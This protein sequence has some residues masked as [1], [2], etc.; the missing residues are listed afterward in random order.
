MDIF[1]SDEHHAL[2]IEVV[3]QENYKT[4]FDGQDDTTQNFLTYQKMEGRAGQIAVLYDS[5]GQ[6]DYVVVIADQE[7][8]LGSFGGLPKI[9]PPHHYKIEGIACEA[10][11]YQAHK[12]I[13]MGA[14][15]FDQ[16]KSV[17][18]K[19]HVKFVFP[20]KLD[21]AKFE[22]E[23][24]AIYLVRDLVNMPANDLGPEGFEQK[25]TEIG[26]KYK[27][28]V[29]T[30]KGSKFEKEFPLVHA[31]GKASDEEPRLF[32][33][34]WGKETDPKIALVG[35]GVCFD[36][37][38]INVKGD[39]GMLHMKKDMGGG[40]HALA[41]AEMIMRA[42]LP[43]HVHLLIPLVKNSVAGN[44]F[45]PRDIYPSRKGLTVEIGH[46]DAEGRLILAD[47]LTYADEHNPDIIIDFA[48]LTGAAR[49]AMGMDVI[50]YFTNQDDIISKLRRT[51]SE[52]YEP[53]WPMPLYKPYKVAIKHGMGDI[54]NVSDGRHYGGAITAALF[55]SE[56]ISENR[57]WIHYDILS[58][59]VNDR[60]ARPK[61]GE[62]NGLATSLKF[63]ID[64]YIK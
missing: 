25:A 40:A 32:E 49:I 63:L 16:Y 41:L 46:T 21:K 3:F 22:N 34:K 50:P 64:T 7:D 35:K 2:P 36:T 14:Y 6:V 19:Q 9:L 10:Y 26:K 48:T 8:A 53:L 20:H 24:L 58:F 47:A 60:P 56:F 61:G 62:A 59:N 51:G 13:A 11:L 23:L 55:L 57:K 28:K 44:A 31:V 1:I 30:H 37:G 18:A 45:L 43:F 33:L 29:K 5:Q 15:A 54:S 27:A 38:G 4:W 12:A 52:C 42:D 17:K 39:A